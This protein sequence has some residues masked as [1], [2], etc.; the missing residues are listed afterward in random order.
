M[1]DDFEPIA[2]VEMTDGVARP[3]FLEAGRQFVINHEGGRTYGEWVITDPQFAPE[4][5]P[6][7][8][9]LIVGPDVPPFA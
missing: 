8:V 5:E 7:D 4:T 3:V 9:P 1:L 2:F 6:Y